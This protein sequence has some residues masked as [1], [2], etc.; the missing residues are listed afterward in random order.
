[1]RTLLRGF[2]L[3]FLTAAFLPLQAAAQ[4]IDYGDYMHWLHT[5]PL[6]DPYN[7]AMTIS[8][9]LIFT[10]GGRESGGTWRFEVSVISL[11]D[12]P[13]NPAVIGS[14]SLGP[15]WPEYY[16]YMAASSNWVYL[17]TDDAMDP[18]FFVIDAT[19]PEHP[20][21][22]SRIELPYRA[23]AIDV[24]GKY[25]YLGCGGLQII[26]VSDPAAPLLLPP[27]AAAVSG[28]VVENDYA[29]ISSGISFSVVD[30][31]NP[32]QPHVVASIDLPH[33]DADN[34]PPSDQDRRA[35][36]GWEPIALSEDYAYVGRLP[37]CVVDISNPLEPCLVSSYE[38]LE[39]LN[40]S[41]AIVDSR[42]ILNT[43]DGVR[44][45]DI[46]DPYTLRFVGSLDIFEAGG[47]GIFHEYG[48]F[49]TGGGL[50]VIDLTHP[51][52]PPSVGGL[53][54]PD[55][56]WVIDVEGNFAYVGCR[57]RSILVLDVAD[58]AAPWMASSVTC[59]GVVYP[60]R[61]HDG[62]L[63]ASWYGY[64]D[65]G[66][67]IFDLSDP[68]HPHLIE[69]IPDRC[70]R[71]VVREDY[72]YVAQDDATAGCLYVLRGSDHEI[73]GTLALAANIYC[74]GLDLYE[75]PMSSGEVP[76]YVCLATNRF[77]PPWGGSLLII[78]VND[79]GFPRVVGSVD[80][81][82][83]HYH[84]AVSDHYVYLSG[85]R[86][87]VID[88]ADPSA[89]VLVGEVDSPG[90]IDQF[91]GLTVSGSVLYAS[92]DRSCDAIDVTDPAHPRVIGSLPRGRGNDSSGEYV[93]LQN[94][95][96]L[97]IFPAQC[98]P[99]MAGVAREP[100]RVL[101][102]L[103]VRPNPSSD[104]TVL[105]FTM[106]QMGP[107]RATIHDA[108][109]RCIRTLPSRHAAGPVVLVWNGLD[110]QGHRAAPGVYLARVA[111][112]EGVRVGRITIL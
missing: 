98:D 42:L 58:P 73:V 55:R 30:V 78:D 47:I 29:Y 19:D 13:A 100:A 39:W 32:A 20:R 101:P 25:A 7:W 112:G 34:R 104:R 80:C 107:V 109:G 83:P 81:S 71:F 3:G 75:Q 28:V 67:S 110:E 48:Y 69:E 60:V 40:R 56:P 76:R 85:S 95:T 59:P 77:E 65:A 57:D 27:L 64:S 79:P 44:V 97:E 62:L 54:L 9:S 72:L 103:D 82:P 1:M 10:A 22:A 16:T 96:A 53:D 91:G 49:L 74:E 99:G 68:A 31:S 46:E 14:V 90:G 26:D 45:V 61:V 52:N 23:A 89:P 4:C 87:L 21:V 66:I 105:A 108:T 12:D 86:V 84:V 8:A 50:H 38:E 41:K 93:Y 24:S 102:F 92:S 51:E 43:V 33:G 5:L 63:Y 6:A 11:V 2:L 37:L 111:T 106:A 17:S 94:E 88:V 36:A 70:G 15:I 18:L 35:G